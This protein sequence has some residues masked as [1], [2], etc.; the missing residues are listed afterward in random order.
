MLLRL[1]LLRG[2]GLLRRLHVLESLAQL[3]EA[4]FEFVHGVVQRLNLAG[5]L[6]DLCGAI[7]LLFVDGSLQ[8]ADGGAHFIGGVGV[9][10]EQILH[11]AHALVKGSHHRGHLLLQLGDLGLQFDDFL[12]GA[13]GGSDPDGE[14][15][16]HEQRKNE[17]NAIGFHS[18]S[19]N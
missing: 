13:V 19:I 11:D 8:L 12:A 9:V 16:R 10:L 17:R 4:D 15:E 18:Y 7:L 2:H 14:E 5:D 1:R 6:V 3:G